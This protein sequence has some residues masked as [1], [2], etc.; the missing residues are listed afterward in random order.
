MLDCGG[1]LSGFRELIVGGVQAVT[2]SEG[3]TDVALREAV[4]TAGVSVRAGVAVGQDLAS[5]LPW[6]MEAGSGPRDGDE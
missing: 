1:L 5:M 6:A 4:E 2:A 3:I